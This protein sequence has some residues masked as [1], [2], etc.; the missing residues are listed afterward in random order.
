MAP[1][2]YPDFE[3]DKQK[4]VDGLFFLTIELEHFQVF[5]LLLI[6]VIPSFSNMVH[7]ENVS[8][9]AHTQEVTLWCPE[10]VD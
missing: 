6:C 1:P 3:L 7:I 8:S 10:T 9:R 2:A 5:I 4:K